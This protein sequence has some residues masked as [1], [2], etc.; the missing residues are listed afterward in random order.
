MAK[1][2]ILEF[3]DPRL[4]KRAAPVEVVDESLRQLIDDMFETMYEAPGIGLAATQVDVHRRLLVA[5]VSQEKD[6]PHVLINAE[7]LEKDGSAVTEEGCLSVPGYYEEVE[8]A[9]HIKVRYLDRDGNE[10]ESEFEGLLAVCVQHEM[11]HLE[12]KLFVDYLSEVKRQRI[13]KRLEKDRR[14]L[15]ESAAVL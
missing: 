5:D 12:G 10:Q 1:L 7:I 11:D 4:R 15:P 3:P 13:R 2:R 8:R 14:K 6:Q 9:E